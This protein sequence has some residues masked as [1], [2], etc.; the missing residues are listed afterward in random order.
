MFCMQPGVVTYAASVHFTTFSNIWSLCTDTMPVILHGFVEKNASVSG[1]HIKMH[2]PGASTR[3]ASV[4]SY[5]LHNL[6]DKFL[7]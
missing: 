2:N 7:C 1:K 5:S 3:I 6:R 4:L